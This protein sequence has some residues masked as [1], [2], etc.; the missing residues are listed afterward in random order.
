MMCD[1]MIES[2]PEL[3]YHLEAKTWLCKTIVED[4]DDSNAEVEITQSLS[5]LWSTTSKMLYHIGEM[6]TCH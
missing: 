4:H 6:K 5:K 1:V 3:M 2:L